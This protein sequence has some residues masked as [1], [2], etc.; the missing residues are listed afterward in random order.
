MIMLINMIMSMAIDL[1]RDRLGW[2]PKA[3]HSRRNG[4]QIGGHSANTISMGWPALHAAGTRRYGSPKVL[5]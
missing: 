4:S 2:L 3:R 5:G 1:F